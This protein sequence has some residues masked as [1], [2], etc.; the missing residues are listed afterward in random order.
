MRDTVFTLSQ[1]GAQEA[2]EKS[3]EDMAEAVRN[4]CRAIA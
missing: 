1:G 2:I 3:V 4:T